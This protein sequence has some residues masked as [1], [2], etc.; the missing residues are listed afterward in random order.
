MV[1]RIEKALRRLSGKERQAIKSI[2]QRLKSGNITGLDIKKLK[3]SAAIYR[4]RKGSMRIM[5]VVGTNDSIKILAIER[6]SNT[7]C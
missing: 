5:Y 2:M 3:G 6:R 1:D 7:R 4:V